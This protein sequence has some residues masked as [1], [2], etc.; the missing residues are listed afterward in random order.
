MGGVVSGPIGSSGI[1]PTI[2]V[3]DR[4][5]TDLD[6]LVQVSG[7]VNQSGGSAFSIFRKANSSAAY[8]PPTGK[9]FLIQAYKFVYESNGSGG[10][11]LLGYN[12][13]DFGILAGG[14]AVSPVYYSGSNIFGPITSLGSIEYASSISPFSVPAGKFPFVQSLATIVGMIMLYGYEV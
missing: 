10:S 2:T 7:F 8:A 3:G 14:P 1:I 6:N 4:V 11:V 12:N 13:S 5:F 9:S